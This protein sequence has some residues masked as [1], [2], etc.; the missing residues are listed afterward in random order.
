VKDVPKKDQKEVSGGGYQEGTCI[1]PTV[2]PIERDV[3]I[4]PG[5]SSTG[6][7]QT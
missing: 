1:P 7:S 4:A 2:P 6:S 5:E 3:T